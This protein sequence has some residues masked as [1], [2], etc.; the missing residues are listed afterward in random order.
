LD[1][2]LIADAVI[3][4][5]GHKKAGDDSNDKSQAHVMLMSHAITVQPFESETPR[6]K[7]PTAIPPINAAAIQR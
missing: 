6:A 7:I 1:V 3:C 2:N 5:R 4:E